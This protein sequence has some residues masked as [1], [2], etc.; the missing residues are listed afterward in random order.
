MH[1]IDTHSHI[2]L[3]AFDSDRDEAI[4]RAVDKQVKTILL[5]NIDVKSIKAMHKLVET[6]PHICFPMIGLHATSVKEDYIEQLTKLKEQLEQNS[7]MAV[8]EI[9]IDLYWDK[10]FIKEQTEALLTQF[11][12][13]IDYH[14]PVVIHARESFN[15][16]FEAI[17][18]FNHPNLTGVFHAFTGNREQ[19][20]KIIALGFKL[21]V[22]G[23]V[24]FKNA[25]LAEVIKELPMEALVL[26]TDSP[27]LAPVPRRG[28]RNESSYLV[29]IAE[30][31]SEI[32]G[33]S[34]EEV[35]AITTMNAKELFGL[36]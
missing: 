30:K 10:T 27:F 31:L 25:G 36:K 11:Q 22:G 14:L 32:K 24:T 19:G 3:S 2:Y 1:L 12:W 7:Y 28:K 6:Y 20:E 15:E 8:G 35:A 29:Y 21:G 26:E 33:I 4:K 18:Q 5:P 9:G 23:I 16:L 17:R 34:L 13:A